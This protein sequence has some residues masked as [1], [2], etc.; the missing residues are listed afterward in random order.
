MENREHNEE[1]FYVHGK[2]IYST[3]SL[4]ASM[5]VKQSETIYKNSS[6]DFVRLAVSVLIMTAR[7][8]HNLR[9]A[10]KASPT[11]KEKAA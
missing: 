10:E 5:G 3:Q 7:G 6:L 2:D 11:P 9:E 4:L 8:L 1:Y